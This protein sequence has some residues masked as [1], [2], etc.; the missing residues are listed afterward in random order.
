MGLQ[1]YISHTNLE[2]LRCAKRLTYVFTDLQVYI[3]AIELD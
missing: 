3:N 1:V 2:N